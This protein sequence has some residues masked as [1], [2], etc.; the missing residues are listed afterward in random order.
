MISIVA[1]DVGHAPD[2]RHM[3]NDDGLP[4][5]ELS[6]MDVARMPAFEDNTIAEVCPVEVFR[7]KAMV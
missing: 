4:G 1:F 7:H 2:G 6:S 5:D 3:C